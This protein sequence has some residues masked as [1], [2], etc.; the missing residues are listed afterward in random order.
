LTWDTSIFPLDEIS[1][2]VHRPPGDPFPGYP[3]G[4]PFGAQPFPI[5]AKYFGGLDFGY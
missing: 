5:N 2:P 3:S 1:A 4:I